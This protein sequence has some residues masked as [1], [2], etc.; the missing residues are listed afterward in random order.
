MVPVVT[1]LVN[2][3][4]FTGIS[5]QISKTAHVQPLIN[6]PSLDDS[7]L[8]S[9]RPISNLPF[10]S[11]VLESVINLQLQVHLKDN[12]LL[13][14]YQSAYR[15]GHSV[16]TALSHVHDSI[17]KQLDSGRTVFLVLLNM[18]AAFAAISHKHLLHV[19]ENRFHLG[20]NV[21]L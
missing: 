6:S 5:L 20:P 18:S 9:Y 21:H 10:V 17:M 11:K 13:D 7:L 14:D 15:I 19:L 12:K 3:A 8:K 4:L 2:L 16:E 1:K